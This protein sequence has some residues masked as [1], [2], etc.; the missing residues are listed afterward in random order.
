MRR[1]NSSAS[2]L[3]SS[4]RDSST[5]LSSVDSTDG[6]YSGDRDYVMVIGGCGYIGSHTALE[7]LK[8]GHN[9]IVVDD[10]SNSYQSVLEKVR[11]LA[12]K[13]HLEAGSKTPSLTFHKLDY[14]SPLMRTVLGRYVVRDPGNTALSH[15]KGVIHFA[16]YKSVEESIH[17]PLDY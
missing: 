5:S 14:R 6:L 15:I 12:N 10:L 8:D 13:H 11:I 3:S 16:A 17:R 7:L 2:S 4:S 9:V 1:S